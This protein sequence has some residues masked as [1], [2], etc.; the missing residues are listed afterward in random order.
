[1]IRANRIAFGVSLLI[2]GAL[3]GLYGL[4]AI[5]YRGDSGGSD[6][7]VTLLGHEIDA[8]LV[9]GVALLIALLLILLAAA[10]LR[11]SRRKRVAR[12]SR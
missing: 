12:T 6:T 11:A 4:F 7:Y 2:A 5:L 8:D 9:G 10:F 3:I 1:M